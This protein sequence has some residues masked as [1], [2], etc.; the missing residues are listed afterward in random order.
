MAERAGIA[1]R[2]FQDVEAGR[3]PGIRLVTIERI[4]KALRIQ[5][6]ALFQP[7][8]FPAPT[9]QRG[10]SGLRIKR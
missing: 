7:G 9:R 1:V 10:K 4:A 3:R 2:H 6:W 8:R 5:V